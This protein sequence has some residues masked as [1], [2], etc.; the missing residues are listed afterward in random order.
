M[1]KTICQRGQNLTIVWRNWLRYVH[2]GL[3]LTKITETEEETNF[4]KKIDAYNLH[5]ILFF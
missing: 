1:T 5:G 3:T 4:G 2:G